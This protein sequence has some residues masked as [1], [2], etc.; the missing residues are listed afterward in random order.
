MQSMVGVWIML[1]GLSGP[2]SVLPAVAIVALFWICFAAIALREW[3]V[4]KVKSD[5]V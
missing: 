2:A 5:V 4:A 3:H 1:L